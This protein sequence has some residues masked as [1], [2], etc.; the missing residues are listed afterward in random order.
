MTMS[1]SQFATLKKLMMLG[2]NNPF[3]IEAVRAFRKATEVLAAAGYDW[4]KALDRVIKVVD[5]SALEDTTVRV[6]EGVV[7]KTIN[8]PPTGPRP[9]PPRAQAAPPRRDDRYEGIDGDFELAIGTADGSFLDTLE[10]IHEQYERKGY[11]SDNQLQVVRDAA[12]RAADRRSAER[13]R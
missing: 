7:K 12:E 6:E 10:S 13:F 4:N 1:T 9:P 8:P 11:L 3:D 5:L 2:A